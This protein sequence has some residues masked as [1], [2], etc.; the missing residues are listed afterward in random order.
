[1]CQLV[2][3]SIEWGQWRN[4]YLD[5]ELT[6][7]PGISR[8]FHFFSASMCAMPNWNVQSNK[9]REIF[10]CTMGNTW[11]QHAFYIIIIF[12]YCRNPF[13]LSFAHFNGFNGRTFH[14]HHSRMDFL[15]KCNAIN[16]LLSTVFVFHFSFITSQIQWRPTFEVTRPEQHWFG[17][18]D[19]AICDMLWHFHEPK[20]PC[21]KF[22]LIN[23]YNCFLLN[24]NYHSHCCKLQLVTEKLY[25]FN[26]V[27]CSD[28]QQMS[29]FQLV[30]RFR[31][32]RSLRFY[33]AP[34]VWP[35]RNPFATWA[36]PLLFLR[37]NL[38]FPLRCTNYA[39][40][41]SLESQYFDWYVSC[42][43]SSQPRSF[44]PEISCK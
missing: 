5:F 43:S 7:L 27:C 36:V 31:P 21:S 12:I 41:W 35:L 4:Y 42:S 24:F 30:C 10:I 19:L 9:Q 11:L 14:F 34:W 40:H 13:F 39:C 15:T 38:G 17:N 6:I 23:S 1:M 20:K 37:E 18:S 25:E 3:S 44:L 29:S 2:P 8:L 32:S 16:I 26:F 22:Y 33:L 28:Q